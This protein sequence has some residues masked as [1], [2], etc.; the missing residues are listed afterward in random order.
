MPSS[1]AGSAFLDS[2]DGKDVMPLSLT[3]DNPLII[4]EH[5]CI[6]QAHMLT[7]RVLKAGFASCLLLLESKAEVLLGSDAGLRPCLT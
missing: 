1:F 5:A 3:F 4:T 6:P 2:P 7:H